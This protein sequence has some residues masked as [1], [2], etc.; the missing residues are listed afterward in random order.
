MTGLEGV[1][2]VAVQRYDEMQDLIILSIGGRQQV[3]CNTDYL[4]GILR[5]TFEPDEDGYVRIKD[6]DT[7]LYIALGTGGYGGDYLYEPSD[8]STKFRLISDHIAWSIADLGTVFN[9]PVMPPA[10]L[11][12]AYSGTLRNC[13]PTTLEESVGNAETRTRR[14][15]FSTTESLQLFSSQTLTFGLS[16]GL[17][18]KAKIGLDI[19]GV[20]GLEEEITL[21]EEI[22][23]SQQYTH[24]QTVGQS[25][26]WTDW[27][28]TTSEVSRVR[29]VSV[30]PYTAVEVYDAI[31][32][33]EDINMPFTQQVRV[34]ALDMDTQQPL[35]GEEIQSQLVFNFVGVLITSVGDY[36][37]D[38]TIRGSAN[39]DQAFEATTNVEELE[40]AC[41]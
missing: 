12:F 1:Y 17:E 2:N 36:Y 11:D 5:L 30:P 8:G 19:E 20:G 28:E 9:Q 37:V 15:T 22:S 18:I 32:T 31:K 4:E 33:I 41:D 39:I 40:N 23:M 10:Q 3:C 25:Q 14:T 21:S 35:T 7:G 16:I 29:T 38:F 26:T 24:S 6:Y 13:A 34:T 27:V